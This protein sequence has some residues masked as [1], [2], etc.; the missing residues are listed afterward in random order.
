MYIR[1][2]LL[3]TA[4]G[5]ETWLTSCISTHSRDGNQEGT[6]PRTAPFSGVLVRVLIVTSRHAEAPPVGSSEDRQ[7]PG[8]PAQFV[9]KADVGKAD[10]PNYYIHWCCDIRE[11]IRANCLSSLVFGENYCK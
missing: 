8:K 10:F 1:S 5:C 4:R 6:T 3:E 9:S 7:T 11:N 2:L